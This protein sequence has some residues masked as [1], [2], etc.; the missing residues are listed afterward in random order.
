MVSSGILLQL[1]K[2]S[3]WIQPNVE[4]VSSSKPI[5]LQSYLDAVSTIEEA[6]IS[7]WDDIE[8]ID[9]RPG[10]GIAKIK[11]KNNWEIQIDIETSEVYAVNYRRSDIIESIHDGSFFS[12]VVKYGWFLP[13]GILLLMLSLTGIYMFFIPILKRRRRK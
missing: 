11:S 10:K 2:Q 9:I 1:K 7:S 5:M 3:N 6:N 12:E 8:R 13:S 4:T